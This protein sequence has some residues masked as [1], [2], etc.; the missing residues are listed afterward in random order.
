MKLRPLQDLILIKPDDD[1][2]VTRGGIYK[3]EVAKEVPT[4]GT[5][6]EVGPGKL[7]KGVRHEPQVKRGDKVLYGKYG[8][9]DIDL[10]G[11][12]HKLI[13]ESDVLGVIEDE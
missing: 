9:N 12:S 4:R 3:P 10:D 7:V 1:E 8:G 2:D 5:V 13:R 11:K 6:V